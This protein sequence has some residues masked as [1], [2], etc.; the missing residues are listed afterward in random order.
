MNQGISNP[1]DGR[2]SCP[3]CRANNFVGQAH[4]WQCRAPLPPPESLAAPLPYTVPM[5]QGREAAQRQASIPAGAYR[6]N[7]G[8]W[9]V[10]PLVAGITFGI[11]WFVGGAQQRAGEAG[12][13][14][15]PPQARYGTPSAVPR[16]STPAGL[17]DGT[18]SSAAA[19]DPLTDQARREVERARS[20]IGLP[21]PETVDP[22][23]R[24]H[25]RSGG[26][27]SMDEWE[28]ARRKLQASPI[29]RDPPPPPPF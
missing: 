24:V 16:R 2:V 23:G 26:T 17:P 19:T 3:R 28:A 20:D 25:L 21:P 15:A 6:R 10:L 9:L 27:L 11:V 8:L 12:G 18:A 14:V 1:G 7:P 4:C 13:T 5:R 22:G 29:L